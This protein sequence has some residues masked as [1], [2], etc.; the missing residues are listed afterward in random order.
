MSRW[1]TRTKA[2]DTDLDEPCPVQGKNGACDAT[3]R[4]ERQAISAYPMNDQLDET[5]ERRANVFA[6]VAIAV[7]LIV[8][9]VTVVPRP[10]VIVM[11]MPVVRIMVSVVVVI[12][13]FGL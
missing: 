4:D 8:T 5:P 7:L 13:W 2:P 6:E 9:P 1:L 3:V 12:H 10:M 11:A